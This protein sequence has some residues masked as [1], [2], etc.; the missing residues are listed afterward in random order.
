MLA[1]YV[2]DEGIKASTF[3]HS[4]L[5]VRD[6]AC[7]DYKGKLNIYDIESGKSK[8]DVQA[9]TGMGNTIHGVGGKGPDYGAPELVTGG[10][11]GCVNVWDP[12]QESPV[13]MLQPSQDEEIKPDCWTVKF[14]NAYNAE[15][16]CVIAGYDNGDVKLFDLR[17]NC[18]K[19]DTNLGNG[20]CGLEFDRVDIPMNK[21]VV[22]TLE[23]KFHIFDLR[24][25]HPEMKY[26]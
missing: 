16:R 2:K 19:W 4:S 25:Y 10:S 9:H 14:G 26:A 22:S 8:F 15:E 21:L 5:S 24:T 20:V 23:S 11:D 6:V 13:M 17:M 12:R 3:A 1:D 18:L 7:V